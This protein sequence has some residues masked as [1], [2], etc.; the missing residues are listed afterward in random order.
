[1]LEPVGKLCEKFAQKIPG[2]FTETFS[3]F[4]R[5]ALRVFPQF[6]AD[7][8]GNERRNFAL[9]HRRVSTNHVLVVRFNFV[10]LSDNYFKKHQ[11]NWNLKQLCSFLTFVLLRWQKKKNKKKFN[12]SLAMY[13]IYLYVQM[14]RFL[15]VGARL[16]K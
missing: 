14:L 16:I 15:G 2:L 13:C 4:V 8:V 12:W 10:R 5:V 7:K 6:D 11:K 1:M 9:H 3:G